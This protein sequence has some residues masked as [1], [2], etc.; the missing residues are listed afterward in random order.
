MKDS[1]ILRDN[2]AL[3][4]ITTIMWLQK[5]IRL[6]PKARGFHLITDELVRE[7]PELRDFRIG[8]MNLEKA[9]VRISNGLDAVLLR[10]SPIL[11]SFIRLYGLTL[12][13]Q[14]LIYKC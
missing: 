10:L 13:K 9:F 6:K 7:L 11:S 8:M 4:I 1:A 14:M 5:E 2:V 12:I 3:F